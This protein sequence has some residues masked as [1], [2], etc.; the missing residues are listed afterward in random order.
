MSVRDVIEVKYLDTKLLSA[1]EQE[2]GA[3]RKKFIYEVAKYYISLG[4]YVIPL[5]YKTKILPTRT[6]LRKRNINNTLSY[7]DG[8]CDLG[9]VESWFHPV[10]GLFA[11]F[12]IG[13]VCGR[14]VSAVDLDIKEHVNGYDTYIGSF[15]PLPDRSPAQKTP[16]GGYHF[17]FEHDPDLRA[18]TAVVPG[19]DI[20]GCK[21][22]TGGAG[23]HIVVYPSVISIHG[24]DVMYRWERGGPVPKAPDSLIKML[25]KVVN[26]TTARGKGRGSE[27]VEDDDIYG[28]ISLD[29]IKKIL[30]FLTEDD[31]DSWISVGM[32]INQHYPDEEGFE[33][34]HEW[35][36]ELDGYTGREDCWYKWNQ[37]EP[38][39]GGLTV[40]TLIYKAKARGYRP[41]GSA[42]PSLEGKLIRRKD[43]TIDTLSNANLYMILDS[44]DL[45]EQFK[46]RVQYDEFKDQV[47]VGEDPYN[48]SAYVDVV[49]WLSQQFGIQ[50]GADV[51]RSYMIAVA[52]KNAYDTLKQWAKSLTWDGESR[53]D[54]LYEAMRIE[55][56]DFEKSA[57]RRWMIGAVARAMEPG[58]TSTHMLVLHGN[59][60]IGKSRFFRA[61]CPKDDWFS[62]ST[63]FKF[64][65]NNSIRDE[66]VKLMGR[67]IIEVAEFEGHYKSESTAIKNFITNQIPVVSKKYD[68]DPTYLPRRCVFGASTNSNSIFNDP[69]GGRRFAVITLEG[70]RIDVD[71]VRDNC[72]QLWAEVRTF[73]EAREQWW[74]NEEEQELQAAINREYEVLHPWRDIILNFSADVS[75]FSY[76]DLYDYILNIPI[77]DRR[78]QD[79]AAIRNILE[80][81]GWKRVST[82]VKGFKS[83]VRLWKNPRHNVD[84][85]YEGGKWTPGGGMEDQF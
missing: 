73:Y 2:F 81:L 61:I 48:N 30:S 74:F 26:I 69:S 45:E 60:G 23:S 82:K 43:G 7:E 67:W 84:K 49:V 76:E 20:R 70:R 53:I 83:P 32:A 11:G 46:G 75:R 56:N 37:I 80:P 50:R 66:E 38:T 13:L 71:W 36:K 9:A 29:Q 59:Q 44:K 63:H 78:P 47:M 25:K 57:V 55:E 10:N 65:G 54:R 79:A 35:S 19:V 85:K 42:S 1:I 51:V 18:T 5:E 62:D 39:P 77:K 12:N 24:E 64:S 58:C 31:Y 21:R 28:P 41:P 22:K 40:G 6:T 4:W 72:E 27:N 3:D 17:L 15:G 14:V 8:S 33:V 34:W 68:P 16:S 52:R